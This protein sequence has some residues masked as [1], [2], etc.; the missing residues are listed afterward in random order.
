MLNW[1]CRIFNMHNFVSPFLSVIKMK[2]RVHSVCRQHRLCNLIKICVKNVCI[3][4]SLTLKKCHVCVVTV[5]R[6]NK[7]KTTEISD[8]RCHQSKQVELKME[9]LLKGKI[10]WFKKTPSNGAGFRNLLVSTVLTLGLQWG[11]GPND[12]L[13][14]I[15]VERES[16]LILQ[17]PVDIFQIFGFFG[18]A[19]NV[20]FS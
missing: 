15:R 9:E 11:P 18:I 17:C 13:R 16:S 8:F 19:G 5:E 10:V 6:E 12:R 1:I 4:I 3:Y 14:K 2:R 20:G 7:T